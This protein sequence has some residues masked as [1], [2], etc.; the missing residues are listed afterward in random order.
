[1]IILILYKVESWKTDKLIS[2][3][4]DNTFIKHFFFF[5]KLLLNS[6]AITEIAYILNFY[7]KG[8]HFYITKQKHIT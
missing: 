1:M 5:Y 3:R 2:L 8:L 7:Q 4:I 6:N